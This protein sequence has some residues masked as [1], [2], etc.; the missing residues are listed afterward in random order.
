MLTS[1]LFLNISHNDILVGEKKIAGILIENNIRGNNFLHA[2]VGTGINV[3]QKEFKKYLPEATSFFL[4]TGKEFAID[5]MLDSLC[6]SLT[7]WY[8][9]LHNEDYEHIS[10]AYSNAL[11]K[12]EELVSYEI[13]NEKIKAKI[14]G[15]NDDGKLLLE[16]ENGELLKMNFKEVKYVF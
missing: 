15:V 4:E 1:S 8:M 2:V 12:I 14:K 9:I 13:A 5:D 11:Y 16:K 3:N 6:K 10:N 7:K